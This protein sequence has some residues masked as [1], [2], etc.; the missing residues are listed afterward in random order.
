MLKAERA[1]QKFATESRL[2]RV[3]EL[4]QARVWPKDLIHRSFYFALILWKWFKMSQSFAFASLPNK[5]F[6]YSSMYCLSMF[7]RLFAQE[8]VALCLWAFLF[9]RLLQF[10][11]WIFC[12]RDCCWSFFFL[13]R[14]CWS[15]FKTLLWLFKRLF[16][17]VL[18]ISSLSTLRGLAWWTRWRQ[19]CWTLLMVKPATPFLIC[20][21]LMAGLLALQCSK[22]QQES[23]MKFGLMIC[24]MH[25]K[26][27]VLNLFGRVISVSLRSWALGSWM[28]FGV[29]WLGWLGLFMA[30]LCS[31]DGSLLAPQHAIALVRHTIAHLQLVRRHMPCAAM[32]PSNFQASQSSKMWSMS[33]R[34][35]PQTCQLLPLRFAFRCQMALLSSRT[36]WTI[37]WP[38]TCSKWKW[39]SFSRST[40]PSTI[41]MAL[42]EA[43]LNQPQRVPWQLSSKL[44]SKVP[45]FITPQNLKQDPIIVYRHGCL[46]D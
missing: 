26:S 23:L 9:K 19:A 32:D 30:L 25:G 27:L 10:V 36:W 18:N 31:Q 5:V 38:M 1:G 37:G 29:M 16:A 39:Q 4:K 13:F 3:Q 6:K 14:D 2:T 34:P 12:W 15:F 17:P 11:G 24:F 42:R 20:L 43:L 22:L 8:I 28:L 40:I 21:V 44:S 7:K 41:P 35:T 45:R 33:W 46:L